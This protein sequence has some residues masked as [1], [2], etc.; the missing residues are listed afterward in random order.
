MKRLAGI[1]LILGLSGCVSREND[2]NYCRKFCHPYEVMA[3]EQGPF[4]ITCNCDTRLMQDPCPM[5]IRPGQKR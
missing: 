5:Y 1:I 2:C 4:G 3:C